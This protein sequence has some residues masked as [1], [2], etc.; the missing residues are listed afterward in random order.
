MGV[1]L[2]LISKA[3][4]DNSKNSQLKY[5]AQKGVYRLLFVPD[6]FFCRNALMFGRLTCS[7]MK[8]IVAIFF[9]VHL[10]VVFRE[11]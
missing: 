2:I 10:C 1:P 4:T 6:S 5:F 7:D 8:N 3:I 11:G 9:V